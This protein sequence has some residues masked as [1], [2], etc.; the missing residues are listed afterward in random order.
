MVFF[1]R[2]HQGLLGS[3]TRLLKFF[4]IGRLLASPPGVVS[5]YKTFVR[6]D[7]A[8]IIDD[9]GRPGVWWRYNDGDYVPPCH[10]NLPGTCAE[11]GL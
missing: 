2:N 9:H 1:A 7:V 3:D 11:C 8:A 6:A 5:I 4:A 10:Y